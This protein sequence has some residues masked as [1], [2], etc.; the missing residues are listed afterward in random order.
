M[1]KFYG[2]VSFTDVSVDVE[3]RADEC[4]EQILES[5]E[6][7]VLLDMIDE[8]GK[9]SID[10]WIEKRNKCDSTVKALRSMLDDMGMVPILDELDSTVGN[11][12]EMAGWFVKK[13]KDM[14]TAAELL[15]M[16]GVA[17][18]ADYRNKD[19]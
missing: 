15:K 17:V 16:F 1:G 11:W 10:S 6:T 3:L 13:I 18:K 5:V 7:G 19:E 4:M 2:N 12:N 14:C 8:A 9:E